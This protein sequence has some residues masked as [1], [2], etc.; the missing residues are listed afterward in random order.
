MSLKYSPPETGRIIYSMVKE[1]TGVAD[2]YANIK[3]QSI[4][5]A[6]KLYPKLKNIV[7]HAEDGLLKAVELAIAGNIIDYGAKNSLDIDKGLKRLLVKEHKR[8]EGE[9][10][11]IF[12]YDIF[13]RHLRKSKGILYLGDNAGESVFDRVLIE[14]ITALYDGRK[15]MYAVREKP[16]INDCTRSEAEKSGLGGCSEII[17]SGSDGPGTIMSLCS[18]EFK[19]IFRAADLIISKGQGN[20]EAL[21]GTKRPVFF[22]FM[23][24]CPVTAREVNCR[25]G[26]IVLL[27]S[28]DEK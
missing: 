4:E 1:I 17:S 11:N 2:P 26:D 25:I 9:G 7:S 19:K 12:Q 8:I 16:I 15:I 6:L 21:S 28:G 18:R 24:K 20:F 22:L 10:R 14:E 5:K 23:A 13:K 27:Y 3:K